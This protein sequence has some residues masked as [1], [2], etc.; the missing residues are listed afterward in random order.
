MSVT[1]M[2]DY[3]GE[4]KDVQANFHGNQLVYFGWDQHL[5]FCAPVCLPLPPDMPFGAVIQEVL[6]SVYASHPDWAQIDWESV[7]WTLDQKPFTPDLGRSL[8]DQGVVHKS[9]LRFRT[10]ELNGIAGSAS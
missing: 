8:E 3:Q 2:Y 7:R 6:P 10:P 1:A 4:P 5:M 9:L